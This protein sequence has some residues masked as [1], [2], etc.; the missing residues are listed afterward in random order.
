MQVILIFTTVS[1]EYEAVKI[2]EAL[3]GERLIACANFFPMKSRYWWKEKLEQASEVLMILKTLQEKYEAV[4]KRIREL[5]SY[6]TPEIIA[7]EIESGYAPYLHWIEKTVK[8]N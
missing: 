3:I 7:V 8:K 6:E 1:G 4:E 2:S 5:H